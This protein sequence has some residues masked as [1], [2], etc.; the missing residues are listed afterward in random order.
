LDEFSASNALVFI[1]VYKGSR[2]PDI[3]GEAKAKKKFKQYPDITEVRTEEGKLCC[4]SIDSMSMLNSA[5]KL[6]A[7]GSLIKI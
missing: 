7:V 3:D 6:I 2:L 1:A 5:T 4:H